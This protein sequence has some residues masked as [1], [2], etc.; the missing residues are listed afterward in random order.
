MQCND[1]FQNVI[2]VDNDVGA[3]G[4][5]SKCMD[6]SINSKPA[7]AI[8]VETTCDSDKNQFLFLVG[9]THYHCNIE[10]SGNIM[11]VYAMGKKYE[12]TCPNLRQA[13]PE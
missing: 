1:L 7:T 5:S 9:N 6:V 2:K 4:D 10:D 8:C 12:F 13:C 3:F 11:E